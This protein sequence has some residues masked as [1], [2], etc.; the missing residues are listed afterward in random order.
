MNTIRKIV[1]DLVDTIPDEKLK[2]VYEVLEGFV[3][4]DV[5]EAWSIWGEFGKDAIEFND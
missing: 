5:D 1:K 2:K 4:S 3:E